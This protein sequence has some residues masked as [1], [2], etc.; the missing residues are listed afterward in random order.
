MIIAINFLKRQGLCLTHLATFFYNKLKE[1]NWIRR[2]LKYIWHPYTQMKDYKEQA[3][4]LIERADG[5]KLYDSNGNVYY[6]T[7]AS[8]WCNVHGHCH[9][10][11]KNAIKEQIEKLDHVLFAGFTHKSAIELAERLV[12][13]IHKNLTKVFFSD[14]GS[15]AIETALKMSFKYWQNIG[16]KKRVSFLSLDMGFHGETLGARSVSGV[17]NEGK[18][19]LK[20]YKAKSPYCYR[21]P[22]K[23]EKTSCNI[24]CISDM[25]KILKEQGEK[26]CAIIIEPLVLGAG[27]MLVYPKEYLEKVGELCKKYNIHLILDEVAT[28]FGRTGKMFA[29]EYTNIEP[30]FLCLS[31]GITSGW[32]PLGVTLT[33]GEIYQ[34]FCGEYEKAFFHGHT[35]TANPISTRVAL[36][37]L[38]IFKEEKTLERLERLIPVFHKNLEKFRELPFVGDVRYIGMLGAFELV[39]DKKTKE[40]FNPKERMGYKVYKKGLEIGLIL[41]PLGDVIYLFPPLSIKEDE[42]LEVLEKSYFVLQI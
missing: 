34:A 24:S 42:M 6:D 36:E 10:K 41:R 12:S 13:I 3:P 21:C 26:I 27:G 1:M 32:L 14:N 37:S 4:I 38:N 23:L 19:F 7:V 33:T 31:K 39:V 17:F 5:V 11:I 25:E 8:W 30:D 2:D 20:S 9:Y 22:K 28:G 18:M 16:N 40:A 15:T 29:Y 35:Y